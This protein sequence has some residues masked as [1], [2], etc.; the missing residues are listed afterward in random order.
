MDP[1]TTQRPRYLPPPEHATPEGLLDVGGRLD[2]D[3]LLDAYTHGI[4]PWPVG[5]HLL[6]WWSPVTA[7]SSP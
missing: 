6:A 1:Y 7:S 2:P 4:F 3:W 5:E